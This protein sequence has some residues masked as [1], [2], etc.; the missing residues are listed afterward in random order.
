MWV[1]IDFNRA[2]S[3]ILAELSKHPI[4]ARPI[5]ADRVRSIVR[6]W[7][8]RMRKFA[9]RR[10]SRAN[11]CPTI[12]KINRSTMQ[13]LP[14]TRKGYAIRAHSANHRGRDGIPMI[15]TNSEFLRRESNG[16]DAPKA[17]TAPLRLGG[18]PRSY[19]G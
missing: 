15:G 11:R 19:G 12:S 18:G 1:H 10:G 9:G 6:A 13:A 14:R 3:D 16:D 2:M 8:L 4:Q 17:N 5:V 7:D